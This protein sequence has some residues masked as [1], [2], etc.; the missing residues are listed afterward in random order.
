MGH[1]LF[2]FLARL[3]INLRL[4]LLPHVAGQELAKRE[5]DDDEAVPADVLETEV[6]GAEEHERCLE[7]L[8]HLP[9]KVPYPVRVTHDD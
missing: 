3:L 6:A 9:D 5:E 7:K 1:A 4:C 2:S 8:G